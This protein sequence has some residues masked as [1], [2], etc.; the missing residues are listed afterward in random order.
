MGSI[1]EIIFLRPI[2]KAERGVLQQLQ[3]VDSSRHT[4][5]HKP[6]KRVDH[7]GSRV[8]NNDSDWASC[9][10]KSTRRTNF[11]RGG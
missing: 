3:A 1:Y 10:A 6:L 8:S 4:T 11:L 5:T 9:N 2:V 7:H